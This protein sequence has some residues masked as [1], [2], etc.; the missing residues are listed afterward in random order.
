MADLK[1][2]QRT[3]RFTASTD[4]F[5]LVDTS[6]TTTKKITCLMWLSL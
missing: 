3:A 2:C 6:A 4:V 1:I 5:P